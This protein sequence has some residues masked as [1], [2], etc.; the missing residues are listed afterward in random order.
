MA[1]PIEWNPRGVVN[2]AAIGRES[3]AGR[4]RPEPPLNRFVEHFWS[5]RWDL[6]GR[7]PVTRET[8]PHP[9]VH[10]VIEEGRSGLAGV[11]TGR[12]VRALEGRGWVLGLKFLPG[13]FRPFWRGPVSD[14]TDRVLGLEEAFGPDGP[15]LESAVL[16]C[17]GDAPA[18][19]AAAEAFLSARLPAPDPRADE[20]RRIVDLIRE[21]RELARAEQV[22]EAAG[23]GLRALQRL[24]GEY[25]GVGP[26]WVLQRYRMHE[27][28]ARLESGE[29]LDLAQLALELGYFDQAHFIRDFKALLGRTPGAYAPPAGG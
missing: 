5:V 22:A 11:G 6:R 21:R 9:S 28:M 27:A 23:V 4:Y 15:A 16:R 26:K 17:E 18:A 12:F 1:T 7:P 25:V 19:V 14:L 2:A 13:C 3:P 10:L 29:A 20:A 24:F 8:L